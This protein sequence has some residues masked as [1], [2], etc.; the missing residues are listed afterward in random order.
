MAAFSYADVV[1][2][3]NN[4]AVYP[5]PEGYKCT[6]T[7]E[8]MSDPVYCIDCSHVFDLSFIESNHR[9][10]LDGTILD[11]KNCI[12]FQELKKRIELTQAET[13]ALQV[14]SYRDNN[15]PMEASQET[16]GIV[17]LEIKKGAARTKAH[18]DD[19]HGLLKLSN[20]LLVSGSKGGDI[21]AWDSNLNHQYCVKRWER[22]YEY[23]I[24][25][26][27]KL[28]DGFWGSGTR[29]GRIDIWNPEGYPAK[30]F[31]Y[32]SA[33]SQV[34]DSNSKVRNYDRIF[35]AVDFSE[36]TT[37]YETGEGNPKF[38][39][40]VAGCI[41]LWD[42][43]RDEI[44]RS[45]FAHERD[46]V[47]C[48]EKLDNNDLIAVVGPH[49]QYWKMGGDS[50][51]QYLLRDGGPSKGRQSRFISDITLLNNKVGK[52]CTAKFNGTEVVYDLETMKSVREYSERDVSLQ[53]TLVNRNGKVQ[54]RYVNNRVWEVKNLFTNVF[55][56]CADD[57]IVK[58]FDLRVQKSVAQIDGFPGRVSS[59]L[60]LTDSN[61]LITG[62]CPDNPFKS[63]SKAEL[64]TWDIRKL[65]VGIDGI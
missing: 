59:M 44:E 65:Q 16:A 2:Q 32:Q 40:G 11:E 29:D 51:M 61:R 57:G 20:G 47:Y 64:S 37:N 34:V 30:E 6:G 58:L 52:F 63:K 24:T 3:G 48:L 9:C 62:S 19:V 38:L 36:E 33:Q 14:E 23:W 60:Y 56:S 10:P 45:F 8:G 41:L 22:G 13:T 54:K 27:F 21:Q 49:L 28:K 12:P 5:F 43:N 7:K 42:Y 15:M 1:R 17:Q 31:L 46:W 26:L 35:C 18:Y 25:T 39:L 55:A 53:K 4:P 50:D